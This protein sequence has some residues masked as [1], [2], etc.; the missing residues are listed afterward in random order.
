MIAT[1]LRVLSQTV[2]VFLSMNAFASTFVFKPAKEHGYPRARKVGLV[3]R[4]R[5]VFDLRAWD[6]SFHKE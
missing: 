5:S 1:T 2:L 6:M 3:G 4:A